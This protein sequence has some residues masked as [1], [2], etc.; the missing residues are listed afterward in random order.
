MQPIL[1]PHQPSQQ[2]MQMQPIPEPT[3]PVPQA[4]APQKPQQHNSNNNWP[5][6]QHTQ[7]QKLSSLL[8]KSQPQAAP[9]TQPQPPAAKP[10]QQQPQHDDTPAEQPAFMAE[11]KNKQRGGGA[12]Q[13]A[14]P[15][16]GAP[17]AAAAAPAAAPGP[18]PAG[19]PTCYGCKQ[20][21]AGKQYAERE[22]RCICKKCQ[23]KPLPML[24]WYHNKPFP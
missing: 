15:S 2:Q 6:Q 18:A 4:Q 20:S 23:N 7:Q 5:P 8:G 9:P 21:L 11:F 16:F 10:V 13:P 3:Q 24:A 1:Q 14:K 12:P 22:G 19:V 17:A